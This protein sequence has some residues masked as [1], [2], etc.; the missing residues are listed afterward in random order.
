[1]VRLAFQF[2]LS[3]KATKIQSIQSNI[4]P[5]AFLNYFSGG[6][7]GLFTGMSFLSLMELLFWISKLVWKIPQ[8]MNQDQKSDDLKASGTKVKSSRIRWK[9]RRMMLR[10]MGPKSVCIETSCISST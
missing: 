8:K 9:K 4:Y 2:E 10:K 6:N 3:N 1:M 5:T 7:F